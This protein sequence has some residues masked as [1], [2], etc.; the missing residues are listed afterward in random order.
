[1]E[2][3]KAYYL[4]K[5]FEIPTFMIEKAREYVLDH[6][7]NYNNE[8]HFDNTIAYVLDLNIDGVI[9]SMRTTNWQKE[10]NFGRNHAIFAASAAVFHVSG[11]VIQESTK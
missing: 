11:A 7:K 1:M 3:I 2:T 6:Y 4:R 10:N 9:C 8:V 5:E